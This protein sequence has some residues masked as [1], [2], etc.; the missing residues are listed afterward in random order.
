M[1]DCFVLAPYSSHR[2]N[3]TH[4]ISGG[5]PTSENNGRK[6]L[7]LDLGII[8]C[9]LEFMTT[10]FFSNDKPEQ[11]STTLIFSNHASYFL[12]VTVDFREVLPRHRTRPAV[13]SS[14]VHY[15]D[16][17]TQFQSWATE[18]IQGWSRWRME[19]GEQME[20][21]QRPKEW[22]LFRLKREGKDLFAVF[23]FLM[24]RCR[25]GRARLFL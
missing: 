21:E 9:F 5:N 7:Y 17:L 4:E 3:D 12:F 15:T 20:D 16:I 23:V 1:A 22:G 10:M 24:G 8:W 14:P 13:L 11:K 18:M 6:I 19:N 25:E 2:A